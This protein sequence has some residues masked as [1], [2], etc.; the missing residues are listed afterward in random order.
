MTRRVVIV[1][2]SRSYTL[3]ELCV[4]CGVHAELALELVAHGVIQ[5]E[6]PHQPLRFSE[7]ALDRSKKALRLRRDLGVDWEG[8]A[9]ALDLLD[10]VERLRARVALLE[11]VAGSERDADLQ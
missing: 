6:G 1:G 7:A 11:R 3:R 9:L 5:A 4:V 8:L 2:S 10:E